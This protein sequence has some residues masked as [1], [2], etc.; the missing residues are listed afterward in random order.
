[1]AQNAH[2]GKTHNVRSEKVGDGV[3]SKVKFT[4]V[5]LEGKITAKFK[6]QRKMSHNFSTVQDRCQIPTDHLHKIDAAESTD[7]I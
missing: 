2:L 7:D 5:C 4:K 6:A 3:I 1:M